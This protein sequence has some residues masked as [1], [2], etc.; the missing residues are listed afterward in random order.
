MSHGILG[1]LTD[2]VNRKLDRFGGINTLSRYSAIDWIHFITNQL[3]K[4]SREYDEKG[5]LAER[6]GPTR[7][8]LFEVAALAILGVMALDERNRQR[9]EEQLGRNK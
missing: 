2:E 3:S 5:R 7:Q 1:E 8:T 4:I 6:M 9:D